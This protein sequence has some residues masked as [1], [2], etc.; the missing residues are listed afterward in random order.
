MNASPNHVKSEPNSGF[1]S[2]VPDFEMKLDN[3]CENNCP[4]SGSSSNI[5]SPISN[6][7]PAS[8]PISN[9]NDRTA[10]SNKNQTLKQRINSLVIKTLVENLEKDKQSV[11]YQTSNNHAYS[12]G[13]DG[14]TAHNPVSPSHNYFV[15]DTWK[16][17]ILQNT[18]VISTIKESLFVTDAI[19]KSGINGEQIVVSLDCEGINLGVKG[20]ITLIEVGTTRG[21]AFIF[22][23]L[24]CPQIMTDGRLKM[25]LEDDRVI[26]VIHDCRNDSVNLYTQFQTVLRNVFDTQSA[27][28]VLQYQDQGKQVYKVKNLSLNTLCELYNAPPNPMKEQLKSVYRRDQKYWARRPLT[29]DMLLYA[30]GDVLVLINEQLYACMAK[31]K[32]FDIVWPPYNAIFVIS[33]LAL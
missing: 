30:A 21:E 25:L 14:R 8:S 26:K 4:K 1:D 33:F 17:K 27:H 31:Y 29:R 13:S 7:S 5:S 6:T 15:G 10:V 11:S 22:D 2:F 19:L 16:I 20:Q 9:N 12:N 18:R 32:L 23:V 3:L 28:A 24:T